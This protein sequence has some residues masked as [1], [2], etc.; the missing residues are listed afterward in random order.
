MPELIISRKNKICLS[1]YNYKKDIEIREIL[2]TFSRFELDILD[3][4][5]FSSITTSVSKV[6]NQLEIT[7]DQLLPVLEKLAGID[8]LKT[9]KE[10][11]SIDKK[12]RKYFEFERMR[13]DE[14]FKPDLLFINNLL[15]KIPIHI[16]PIWYVIPKSSNN[17]FESII[18][19]Y[20]LSPQ[21]FQR[22][23]EDLS[24]EDPIFADVIHNIYTSENKEVSSLEIQERH[25]LSKL[26]FLEYILLLEFNLVCVLSYR[27]TEE[28][29][30]EILTPFHEYNEYLLHLKKTDTKPIQDTE[31]LIKKRNSDFGFVEDLSSILNMAKKSITVAQV[32]KN[33]KA[34]LNV[35]EQD[36]VISSSYIDN[37]LNKLVQLKF[38]TKKQNSIQITSLGQKWNDFNL[39]NKALHL[40][41][42]PLNSL[43]INDLPSDFPKEILNEKS[44]REAEKS[45]S[46]VSKKGWVFFDDFINGVITPITDSHLIKMKSFGKSYKYSLPDYSANEFFFIKKIIFEKLFESG[47]VS[48]GAL[49]NKDCFCVTKLGQTLF[50][51]T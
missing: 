16:L 28:G 44:I 23:L 51:L 3:E 18:N 29:F 43:T 25:K 41:Y 33:M 50:D 37:L 26:E 1:D 30:E 35:K 36:I 8:L 31:K 20:L 4:L 27:K 22:H 11:I 7:K 46:R 13:F 19:K 5:L 6:S 40:F 21:I 47:I 34:E 42:H 10:I 2:S 15:Q 49:N 17:I 12:M 39:E 45:I 14:N 38:I 9:D 32:Q 24:H 48:I